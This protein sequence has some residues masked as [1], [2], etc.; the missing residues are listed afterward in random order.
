MAKANAFPVNK[1]SFAQLSA[2]MVPMIEK[3][4]L[5]YEVSTDYN[6]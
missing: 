2:R 6:I 3:F 4:L 5:R 1:A